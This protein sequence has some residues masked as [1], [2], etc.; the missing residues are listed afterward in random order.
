MDLKHPWDFGIS[1]LIVRP[2]VLRRAASV[3][4][5]SSIESA[6]GKA[7]PRGNL[8]FAIRLS[9][10]LRY[11]L[12]YNIQ[13]LRARLANRGPTPWLEGSNPLAL[14]A[15]S[16]SDSPRQGRRNLVVVRAGKN[17]LHAQW[18]DAG[19]DR[20]W[21][22]V[23][24]VYDPDASFDHGEDVVVVK[25]RGGKWDGLYA[26][27]SQ[28]DILSRYDY[29]WL[30]DDDIATSSSAIGAIFDAMRLYQ[31]EVAQPSLTHDSYSTHFALM[32]CPGF[33]LRYTNYIE[34]MVPCLKTDLF[35]TILEDCKTSMSGWG[36]D[37]IWCRLSEHAY[38]KAAIIDQVAVHHTRPLGKALRGQMAKL[39]IAP[40]DE[41]QILR[42]RY[43]VPRRITPLIYAAID[44]HGRLRE[45]CT[46]L[47]FAMG[48]AYLKVYS[49]FSA[50]GSASWKILRLLR[51]QMTLKLDLSQLKRRGD[52]VTNSGP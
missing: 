33:F 24:S 4:K 28:S 46:R 20:N 37:Y 36:L 16:T 19:Q 44:S 27:F 43:S 9:R 10:N 32:S 12:T 3:T 49:Q 14:G 15:V 48:W 51:R 25:Q 47:G 45:G 34:V 31:L 17:S 7:K 23:V 1:V 30:P 18:L 41:E 8:G 52:G 40:K 11:Q 50:P 13:R 39:G 35:Q 26:L 42:A 29:V 6:R 2:N 22:L 5:G 21:D 38:Y